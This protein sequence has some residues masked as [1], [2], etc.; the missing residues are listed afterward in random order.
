VRVGVRVGLGVN[1]GMKV[2]GPVT[3]NPTV[4]DAGNNAG[5]PPKFAVSGVIPANAGVRVQD[6]L[7]FA[8]VEPK[9]ELPSNEICTL[10]PTTGAAGV[11]ETS[12][13][14][15][16]SVTGFPAFTVAGLRLSVRKL[17]CGP[18]VHVITA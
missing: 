7:P 16:I 9:Q 5:F 4:A 15:A 13:S 8:S 3:L 6:A 12:L 11:A 18:P 14:E 17:V 2:G 1:V 10:A